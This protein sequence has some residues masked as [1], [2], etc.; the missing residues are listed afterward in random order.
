MTDRATNVLY[1]GDNLE[2]HR[3]RAAQD[4]DRIA[5]D[6]ARRVGFDQVER[7]LQERHLPED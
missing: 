7:A 3:R 5:R 6:D 1:Y 4:L 2:V